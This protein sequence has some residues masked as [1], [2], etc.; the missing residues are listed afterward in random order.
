MTDDNLDDTQQFQQKL[1]DSI[2]KQY[3][4]LFQIGVI[5]E[6]RGVKDSVGI[7]P[8]ERLIQ[9]MS[10]EQ[11]S[12]FAGNSVFAKEIWNAAIEAVIPIATADYHVTAAELRRLK[13]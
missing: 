5:A 13:K 10:A 7:A 12:K 4:D 1:I 2:D 8:N 9:S 6:M 11:I 3:Q